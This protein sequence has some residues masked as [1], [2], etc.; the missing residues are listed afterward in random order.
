MDDTV[1]HHLVID[2]E[3]IDQGDVQAII[4][5]VWWT[6]TIYDGVESYNN[7]LAA[8]SAQQRFI[9]AIMWYVAEVN[10]GGHDQFY[11]NST[12]IVWKD[13]LAGF[14]ELQFD[15]AGLI[16]QESADRMGGDPSLDRE[17]RNNQL[18]TLHPDFNDL[19]M[20]YYAL[21]EQLFEI[22]QQYIREHRTAFYFDGEVEVPRRW[23]KN[24]L[25]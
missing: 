22:M 15:E 23:L 19:D 7:S 6:A 5:P 2:D 11:T 3:I 17:T 8:F 13:V 10:N 14:K 18:D 21:E 24:S 25:D 16:I 1:N 20:Q 12:G 4:D 9:F